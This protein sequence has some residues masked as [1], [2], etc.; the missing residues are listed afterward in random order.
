MEYRFLRN[1]TNVKIEKFAE[2]RRLYGIHERLRLKAGKGAL[3]VWRSA[4][5]PR[6]SPP[7]QDYP[8]FIFTVNWFAL[9]VKMP[10]C[11]RHLLFLEKS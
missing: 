9:I 8:N 10:L 3:A 7:M 11:K 4:V 1:Y 2:H 5:R 6:L